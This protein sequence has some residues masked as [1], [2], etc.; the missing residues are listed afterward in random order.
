MTISAV[1]G[2]ETLPITRSQ[3]PRAGRPGIQWCPFCDY[4][5]QVHLTA[6]RCGAVFVSSEAQDAEWY[7]EADNM[8]IP[9]ELSPSMAAV[10]LGDADSYGVSEALRINLIAAMESVGEHG[11]IVVDGDTVTIRVAPDFSCPQCDHFPFKTE[12]ALKSHTTRYHK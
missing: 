2:G 10:L 12:T 5:S 1:K 6:C 4:S 9:Q 8:A 7:A 3:P 11:T